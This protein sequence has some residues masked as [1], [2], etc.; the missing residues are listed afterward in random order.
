MKLFLLK[1]KKD[2]PNGYIAL[3]ALL[4]MASV[5]LAI[6]VAVSLTSMN[7][8]QNSFS[9]SQGL[10]AKMAANTCVEEGLEKLRR[11]W[12]NHFF[13]LLLDQNSC[14]INVVVTGSNATLS[15]TGT[16]GVFNQKIQVQADNNLEILA[17]EEE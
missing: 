6:G 5:G 7:E 17:W 3:M 13:T 2:K 12:E 4:I 14:I 11:N 8:I 15:A 1:S 9:Q 16:A 10:S